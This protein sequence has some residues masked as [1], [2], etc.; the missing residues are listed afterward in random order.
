M[1]ISSDM[2]GREYITISEAHKKSKHY[3]IE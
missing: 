1:N 2:F 3:M